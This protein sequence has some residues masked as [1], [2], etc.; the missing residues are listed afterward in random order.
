MSFAILGVNIA[1]ISIVFFLLWLASLWLEDSSI[2]DIFWGLGFVVIAWTTCLLTE[3]NPRG[4]LV[5]ILATVWGIRLGGYLAWRNIGKGED[6]RYKEMRDYHGDRFPL[7]SLYLVFGLQG[8]IMLVVSLP[9]Q[10]AQTSSSPLNFVDYIAGGLWLTGFLFESI[11]DLQLARFKSD[12]ENRGKVMDR[13]LWRFTRHP[14]YFG[15]FL[16]WWAFFC[17]A[18]ATGAFWAVI[19]PLI[20]SY[21][22]IRVSGVALLEQS[23]TK[24]RAGYGSYIRRTSSLIP[25][26]PKQEESSETQ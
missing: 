22:L 18:A 21:F 3:S 11:G 26:P 4:L 8:L 15:D 9:L 1:V 23:L 5:A 14:N 12:S 24:K 7:V 10:I 19:S 16:V 6:Y 25:W 20:M 13:G 2:V 17:F